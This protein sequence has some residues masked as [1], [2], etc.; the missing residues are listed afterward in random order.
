MEVQ[1]EYMVHRT[2]DELIVHVAN[3]PHS[4]HLSDVSFEEQVEA[5][6]N[7]TSFSFHSISVRRIRLN[8][9]A[10]IRS[11]ANSNCCDREW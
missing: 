11:Y 7:E 6:T 5:T 8:K 1:F 4:P 10:S 2:K 3:V 9:Q